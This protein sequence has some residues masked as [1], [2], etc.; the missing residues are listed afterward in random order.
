MK[1]ILLLSRAHI[2]ISLRERVTLFW[3]LVFPILL[4]SI[5]ALIFGNTGGEGNVRFDIALVNEDSGDGFSRM[6]ERAFGE[7]ATPAEGGGEGIFSLAIPKS[8]Q[9]RGVRLFYV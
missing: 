3:F 4:L 2:A 7:M 5:L 8:D 9:D 6:I 1:G